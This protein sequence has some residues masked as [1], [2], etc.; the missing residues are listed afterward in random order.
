MNTIILSRAILLCYG[1]V[2]YFIG[3]Y[4]G[5]TVAKEKYKIIIDTR[6]K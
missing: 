5:Y 4:V 3:C 1:I 2:S 6:L